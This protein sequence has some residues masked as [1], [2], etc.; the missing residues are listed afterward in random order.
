VVAR[1]V[2]ADTYYGQSSDPLSLNLYTY[3]HNEPLMYSDPTGHSDEFDYDAL[4]ASITEFANS[5]PDFSGLADLGGLDALGNMDLSEIDELSNMNL[6][7]DINLDLGIISDPNWLGDIHETYLGIC[8]MSNGLTAMNNGFDKLNNNLKATNDLLTP[9]GAAGVSA[10]ASAGSFNMNAYNAYL[11]PIQQQ[12]LSNSD[13]V[14]IGS[15]LI[16]G[17]VILTVVTGGAAAPILVATVASV[18][19]GGATG[20]INSAISYYDENGTLK[21]SGGTVLQGAGNTAAD[22]YMWGGVF[23]LAGAAGSAIVGGVSSAVGSTSASVA[24]GAGDAEKVLFGQK[25]VSP[26]FSEKG[27]FNGASIES[28]AQKLPAGEISPDAL[29]IEY[30]VRDGKMITLN[31]RSLT[32]L[33]KAGMQ[34]TQLIDKT[35]NAFL[36]KQLTERLSEM[37]GQPSTTM[38][39]RKLGEI[40]SIP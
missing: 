27:S 33:S 7:I 29:P 23:G 25:S 4:L 18:V 9:V 8:S 17:E 31:N 28:I 39:I 13:K 6:N 35:G 12:R 37:G 19:A 36:E 16:A 1:F 10:Q 26:Y 30:I 40:V 14:L 32:A 2:S 11:A 20:A 34:P 21:G 38:Y 5:L 3:C 22:Y 15:I 24:E